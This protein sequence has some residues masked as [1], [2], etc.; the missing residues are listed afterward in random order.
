M[1]ISQNSL[2]NCWPECPKRMQNMT[3]FT[4]HIWP[5]ICVVQPVWII[6][7]LGKIVPWLFSLRWDL[8]Y[9]TDI[10]ILTLRR[11]SQVQSLI[12][13]FCR[14]QLLE[15]ISHSTIRNSWKNYS[16]FLLYRYMMYTRRVRYI[17]VAIVLSH[18][19]CCGC[20]SYRHFTRWWWS[21]WWWFWKKRYF[22][23]FVKSD[24]I[25]WHWRTESPTNV[26]LTIYAPLFRIKLHF[27]QYSHVMHHINRDIW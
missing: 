20:F 3:Q 9:W 8:M 4:S 11:T 19:C 10:S 15:N 5:C 25:G 6:S 23:V 1:L 16:I 7:L 22:P 12:Y 14:N 24:F 2:L 27:T 13:Q 21:W 17:Y 26:P 18:R